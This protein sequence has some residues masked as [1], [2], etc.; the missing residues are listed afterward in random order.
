MRVVVTG[1]SGFIGQHLVSTLL[2]RGHDVLG[3]DVRD[4]ER[5]PV[6]YR[7]E[8][9]DILDLDRLTALLRA[10]EPE[11]L[12]HLAACTDLLDENRTGDAY[13]ANVAGVQNV[14]E[15]IRA[16]PSLQR[17]L[18]AST[19]L[20]CRIGYEP[21]SDEDYLPDTAYGAS[22]VEGEK[23]IRRED[24]GGVTWCIVRPTTVWG[25][26][27]NEHYRRFFRML[28]RGTYFHVGRQPVLKSF[29]YVGNVA[30]QFLR[31]LEAPA[32][33]IHRQTLYAG[34]YEPLPLQRWSE[35]L[36]VE[37]GAPPIRT[38]P[39]W[40]ARS[41]ARVGDTINTMG[42]RRFPFNSFRLQNVLTSYT[43]DMEST[44]AICGDNPYSLDRAVQSTA[45]WFLAEHD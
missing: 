17:V 18:L 19:Q 45:R 27:M 33:Q 12:I 9:G 30:H 39:P 25:P 16:T 43:L 35:A 13:A 44:R 20:V 2:T 24:G 31:M 11:G 10:F 3:I 37:F 28:R 23:I 40:V 22:K 36:R 15:A 42:V 8:R 6:G 5:A 32:K 34:D 14:V 21:E 26:G 4:P 1:S 41:L 38:M 29:G 7:S